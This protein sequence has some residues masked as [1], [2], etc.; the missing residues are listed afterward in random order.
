M[1]GNFLKVEPESESSAVSIYERLTGPITQDSMRPLV[2]M[3][4]KMEPGEGLTWGEL[5]KMAGWPE[6]E[7]QAEL[8]IQC[9]RHGTLADGIN[10]WADKLEEG[11]RF[12]LRVVRGAGVRVLKGDD[13][14]EYRRRFEVGKIENATRNA[15]RRLM[16]QLET[17]QGDMTPLGRYEARKVSRVFRRMME[18]ATQD[19]ADLL[20]ELEEAKEH[21]QEGE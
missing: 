4:S 9:T 18:R 5:K 1:S 12:Q 11:R 21:W 17:H 10:R 2:H 13:I 14:L 16:K 19:L 20:V 8:E 15:S 7:N 3:I 6:P